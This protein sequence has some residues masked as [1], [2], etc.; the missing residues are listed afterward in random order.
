MIRLLRWLADQ[1]FSPIEVM[2]AVV[3]CGLCIDHGVRWYTMVW[4]MC[5]AAFGSAWVA[6][7][8]RFHLNER[9][10]IREWMRGR[11]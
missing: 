8:I 10:M 2:A 11:K 6:H 3:A 7:V 4:F 1:S 9:D 5:F